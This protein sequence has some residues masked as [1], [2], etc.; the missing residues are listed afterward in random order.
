MIRDLLT[1]PPKTEIRSDIVVVG[2]GTIG[3]VI[4]ERL[5]NKGKSVTILEAGPEFFDE[6]QNNL[7]N[8]VHFARTIY[9]G[10][11]NGRYRC[12]GGTSIRWGGALIPIQH[13]D[14]PDNV[15][16]IP[17]HELDKYIPDVEFLFGLTSGSYKS[18]K[19]N[20]LGDDYVARLAKWP[21]FK[22]RNTAKL[23]K[24]ELIANP[25]ITIY[26]NA[27]LIQLKFENN[28]VTA[29]EAVSLNENKVIVSGES[30]IIAAG[31]IETTRILLQYFSQFEKNNE[32]AK[33]FIGEDFSDHLSVNVAS[34]RIKNRKV[35]NKIFG[36]Q[37]VKKGGMRNL[38]F[39]MSAQSNLRG[40]IPPH[41]FH[42]SFVVS[43]ESGFNALR[44]VLR[45][46]QEGKIPEIKS[47]MRI[48]IDLPWIFKALYWKYRFKK[49]LYPKSSE[50]QLHLVIEQTPSS[51]NRVYLSRDSKDYFGSP[52]AVIDW[53]PMNVDLYNLQNALNHFIKAWNV[54][55]YNDIAVL[56]IR[57]LDLILSD[58]HKGAGIFHPVGT[59]KVGYSRLTS[60]VNPS[61]KVH[62]SDNLFA[63][64]T[65]CLPVGGGANPTMTLLLLG[66]R[67]VDYLT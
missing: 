45:N 55:P 63:L 40:K 37:F 38:R 31:A 12:L 58:L 21:K 49:L 27:N 1:H 8:E 62:G 39:E 64:S 10:A 54:S 25:K 19:L 50:I 47:I 33:F 26:V 18:E 4:A 7:L 13:E 6:E 59:T 35:F 42:V 15:W 43:Q 44:E 23:L 66:F 61:L 30:F 48:L 28:R 24:N 22:N 56:E 67:L 53:A 46:L 41:F 34:L 5:A 20:L 51:Q 16:P 11:R 3:L 9:P 57:D 14:F 36:Y 60:T 17:H 2:G 32:T 52:L 29:A 65:S